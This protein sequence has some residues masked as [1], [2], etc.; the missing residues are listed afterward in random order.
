MAVT[1]GKTSKEDG[2]RLRALYLFPINADEHVSKCIQEAFQRIKNMEF[3]RWDKL[4][5]G[6]DIIQD[7]MR[8]MRTSDI[9]VLILDTDD[10]KFNLNTMYE[11]GLAHGFRRNVMTIVHRANVQRLPFDIRQR[12]HIS[13]GNVLDPSE[14]KRFQDELLNWCLQ[15]LGKV[16]IAEEE[17]AE[18]KRPERQQAS[19]LLK[20][21]IKDTYK[22]LKDDKRLAAEITQVIAQ[23]NAGA[24]S[25]YEKTGD[26]RDQIEEAR[27]GGTALLR[28]MRAVLQMKASPLFCTYVWSCASLLAMLPA[29]LLV[30]T[31]LRRDDTP[32]LDTC[33]ACLLVV[34][35][36]GISM[37][38]A[39]TSDM[40]KQQKSKVVVTALFIVF[41][42][43]VSM[44][45]FKAISMSG[46]PA[47][48][49]L[50][51]MLRGAALISV[52]TGGIFCFSRSDSVTYISAL[53]RAVLGGATVA[54]FFFA[55][56]LTLHIFLK[57]QAFEDVLLKSAGIGL[58]TLVLSFAI[59][60]LVRV[61]WVFTGTIPLPMPSDDQ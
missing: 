44:Y 56:R 5:G 32:I 12:H 60:F 14:R 59:I 13:Y 40:G 10:S 50:A 2:R 3:N 31:F 43:L 36:L 19:H 34:V 48:V 46:L 21:Q 25:T 16:E 22:R 20:A 45:V 57:H 37:A 1:R 53:K 58:L 38:Y 49:D 4:P 26:A 8:Y 35:L 54:L 42:S 30:P 28:R 52:V 9:V 11:L 23:I 18:P 41:V 7:L 24:K 51:M 6:G 17:P 33:L 55:L 47:K 27:R 29:L 61:P 15:H 39:R